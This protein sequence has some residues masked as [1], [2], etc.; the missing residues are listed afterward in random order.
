MVAAGIAGGA[1]RLGIETF[2]AMAIKELA[3]KQAEFEKI[4]IPGMPQQSLAQALSL[5]TM[6]IEEF[7]K[8][9]E[10]Y[11]FGVSIQRGAITGQDML[12][13]KTRDEN[14]KRGA[15]A[16]AVTDWLSELPAGRPVFLMAG[17]T[18]KAFVPEL[19][20]LSKQMMLT[21]PDMY[22]MDE[23]D[24]DQMIEEMTPLLD[25]T[26]GMAFLMSVPGAKDSPLYAGLGGILK[27]DGNAAQYID[28]Y[29]EVTM[30]ATQRM[31]D[32][33]GK[34]MFR[35]SDPKKVEVDG[36][37]GMRIVVDFNLANMAGD[38]ADQQMMSTVMSK[39]VGSDGKLK[40]FIVAANDDTVVFGYTSQAT[41]KRFIAAANGKSPRTLA[42]LPPY[43]QLAKHLPADAQWGGAIDVGGYYE[44]IKRVMPTGLVPEIDI[45]PAP[46]GIAATV[47]E[48]EVCIHGAVT[49]NT[50]KRLVESFKQA[51]SPAGSVD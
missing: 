41:A 32:A 21:M 16:L 39:M 1:T 2:A 28:D 30:K 17:A 23:E 24:I 48:Q 7:E 12:R 14:R 20:T 49:V 22:G 46:M 27:V 37:P 25:R 29:A 44:L 26:R 51:S 13:M 5:Y 19:L 6:L 36:K 40:V 42:A 3:A 8:A 43:Q 15:N 35:I 9:V 34:G 31:K 50:L 47:S 10:C 4:E 18:P 38:T 45:R 11:A 33:S